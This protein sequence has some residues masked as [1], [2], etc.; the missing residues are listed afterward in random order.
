MRTVKIIAG[1]IICLAGLCLVLF[2]LSVIVSESHAFHGPGDVVL[3][4]ALVFTGVGML[5]LGAKLIIS[6]KAK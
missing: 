1:T 2:E 3:V 4:S 6:K 5:I